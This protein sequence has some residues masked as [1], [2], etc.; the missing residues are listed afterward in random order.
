[1]YNS[2]IKSCKNCKATFAIDASDFGFYEKINVPPPTFCPDCRQKRRIIF[3]N[4]KTLYKR[5]SNKSGKSI[6]AMYSPKVPY[7][8]YT[9][10]EWW[11]DEWDAKSY[12]KNFDFSR[13][14]FKQFNE[15]L[16]AV[17]RF[18]VMN[19]QSQNCEYSNM[20]L[21][22]KNCYLVFGCVDNEDCAYGHIV[23]E[24]K[25][26]LDNLY[27]HHSELCYECVDCLW[28]YKLF[29]SQECESCTESV[30]LYD[31]R[32][33]LNCIGC[34]GLQ[35]KSYYIFN[36][37][38]G[39][40]GYEKFLKDHPLHDPSA[41]AMILEKQREL[42]KKVPQRHF[43]G[44]HNNSA[45]G[46]HLYNAK[47]VHHSF[48]VKR[49]ED[50]KYIFTGGKVVDSYDLSFVG[51]GI[52]SGYEA[53]TCGGGQSTRFSHIVYNSTDA[54]YSDTCYSS[55]NI[56]GCSG[57]RSA[58]YC[59]LN[60]QYSKESF[61]ELRKKIIEHMKKTGEWGEFFPQALSPFAYN[62]SIISEYFPLTK[63]E[64][65]SQGYRWEDDIPMTVGQETTSHD[66]LPARPEDY[67]PDLDNEI[68][69]CVSCRRNY[70]FIPMEINFLKRSALF[71]PRECFNCRHQRRMNMRNPRMLWDGACNRCDAVFKTSYPPDKQKELPIFCEACYKREMA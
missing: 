63:E 11:S 50:S 10:E 65:L 27:V 28:S 46:N 64:A 44:S 33:C 12:G 61:D 58:E 56:F 26:C 18:N 43:F 3:R 23:W 6:I 4:F 71:L 39:K 55:R 2:E 60:K 5:T 41:I 19:I 24:S 59:I 70:R 66:K 1:M 31:C 51:G 8:V 21:R 37:N 30:G 45:S 25:D 53:I 47:N 7:K 14:F 68:L 67:Q 29:Y 9:H 13:P 57:L 16:L 40:A 20:T 52:E 36:E 15:L 62:E 22:S 34:V 54:W 32:G 48:D 42:R 17:P 49:G 69:A 38:V 35:Q